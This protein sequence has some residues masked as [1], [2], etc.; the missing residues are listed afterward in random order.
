MVVAVVMLVIMVVVSVALTVTAMKLLI[1]N[2]L[3]VLKLIDTTRN[4]DRTRVFESVLFLSFLQET[5]KQRMA[6][7]HQRNHESV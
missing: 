6:Q 2:L 3:N 7:E 5:Q 1:D 4:R